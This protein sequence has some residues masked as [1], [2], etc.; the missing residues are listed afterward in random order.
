M[1]KRIIAVL[2]LGCAAWSAQ[3]NVTLINEGF[4]NFNTLSSQGWSFTNLSVNPLGP[5]W[6]QGGPIFDAQSGAVDSYTQASFVSAQSGK[7]DAWLMTPTVSLES[8]GTLSFFVRT[9]ELSGFKDRLQVSFSSAGQSTDA[10]NFTNVLADINPTYQAD[11]IPAAWTQVSVIYSGLGNGSSGRFGFHYS[12]DYD[13]A[14]M[15]AMDTINIQAIPE[16]GSF[17][18]LGLG[19]AGLAFLRRRRD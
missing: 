13:T 9:D 7:I 11:G 15:V 18:L 3:A 1:S 2:A 4:D 17:A 14:N 6:V 10:A 8:G 19:L 5:G 12:G 16:P